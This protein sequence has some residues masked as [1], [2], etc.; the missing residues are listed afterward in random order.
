M[1]YRARTLDGQLDE[2]LRTAP[3]IAIEGPKGVGKTASAARRA[4]STWM[5]DDGDQRAVLES[6]PGLL[7][8]GGAP[9]LIDEWQR[10]PQIWDSVRRQVDDGA[11]PGSFLLT[12]SATPASVEGTHSGSG[13]ILSLRMRPMAFHERGFERPTVSLLDALSGGLKDVSGTTK[14]ATREYFEAIEASGFPGM[15]ELPREF[16]QDM[17]DA[18]LQRIVDRDLPETGFRA[19]RPETLR[20][21]LGAYA[22]ASS[23]TAKYSTLLDATTPG[24]GTQPT[25]VTTIAYRE[26]LAKLWLLDPVP[27][28]SPSL[29]PFARLQQAPKHQLADPALSAR[30]LNLTARSLAS[31][32]GAHMS[33][34]LFESLVTLGVRVSAQAA[35]ARVG[36]L[37][38]GNGDREIDL[39]V[40][41]RE[42]QVV[43]I[44]VKLAATVED[45]DVRH[46]LWL[47][48]K[49][50]DDVADLL[51][52]TT[53]RYAYRRPDGVAVVP[54]A[55]LGP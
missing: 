49:M 55:L 44:E 41:G 5:L 45:K 24:D 18:Y 39:I 20:R 50:G 34:P 7:T 13:R 25:K 1:D 31:P 8:R 42:G 46:L 29:S 33:G 27:G 48:D 36:H 51:L 14:V 16:R 6:D 17:L 11:A 28:W 21:W 30:L 9:A 40:E 19:R 2:L 12:G 3:A 22:A 43:G 4:S 47:R 52:V 10:L 54:L 38:S 15:T 26:H 37:R 23:T 35:R 32:R 53:G